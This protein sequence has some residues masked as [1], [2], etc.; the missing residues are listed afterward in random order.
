EETVID[1]PGKT[2]LA[3]ALPG[4]QVSLGFLGTLLGLSLALSEMNAVDVN[5]I[6][7]SM[8]T[9]LS[10]MKYAFL[11]SIFGVVASVLFTLLTRAVHSKAQNTLTQ[12]YNAMARYAGVLSVD[13]LTQMA[14]YQQEQ[15]SLLREMSKSLTPESL[16]MLFDPIAKT[17]D[18]SYEGQQKLMNAVAD[19]YIAKLNTALN[20]QLEALSNT[21]QSTCRYQEKTVKSVSDALVEFSNASRAIHDIRQDAVQLLDKMDKELGKLESLAGELSESDI[22]ARKVMNSQT[23][24]IDALNDLT[25]SFAK[26]LERVNDSTQVFLEG[27]QRLSDLSAKT[28]TQA[29]D[30]LA[31]SASA[32]TETMEQARSKLSRDMDESLN[33]FEGC[34]TQIIKRVEKASVAVDNATENLYRVRRTGDNK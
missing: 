22:N 17:L 15:T 7:T 10:S 14:I 6:T 20:G 31:E 4:L 26:Q 13:P 24:S 18:T 8:N 9:L 1:S 21:I 28:L 19:A 33:Y 32:L 27:A 12:F 34:M 25:G 11:T 29:G 5:N 30:R 16:K 2:K 23:E 3:E